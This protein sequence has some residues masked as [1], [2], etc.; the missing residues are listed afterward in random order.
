MTILNTL[1]FF[2]EPKILFWP[3]FQRK[4]LVSRQYRNHMK[5]TGQSL[6]IQIA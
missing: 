4:M 5:W 3:I 1:N 6:N 2:F